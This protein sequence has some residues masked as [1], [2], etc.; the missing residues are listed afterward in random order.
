MPR[1]RWVFIRGA[2]GAVL[3]TSIPSAAKAASK[4][5]VYFVSRSRTRR[6][7]ESMRTPDST[8]RLRACR[9]VLMKGLAV[10]GV[11]R[12]P[13]FASPGE[14]GRRPLAL[15]IT[16]GQWGD[17]PQLIPVLERIRVK[18]PNGGHAR[19]RPD[20]SGGDKEYSFRR[21]RRYL[22][23]HQLKHTFPEPKD[24]Q[25]NRRH[26]GSRG[27]GPAGFD[28]EMYKRRNEVE[29]TINRL[30]HSRAVTTRY[31]EHAYVFHGTVTVASVRLWLRS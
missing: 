5:T 26:R 16:P 18:R 25:A 10:P 14:G 20:H 24:Q 31:D 21:N 9:T 23:R 2:R 12:P 8:A 19:T 22:R 15:L 27:G 7:G 1:S 29:R 3:T 17:S 13:R 28:K 4:D 30:K 6:C 11:A